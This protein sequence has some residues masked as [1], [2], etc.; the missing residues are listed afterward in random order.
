MLPD[1]VKREYLSHEGVST[2]RGDSIEK[3]ISNLAQKTEKCCIVSSALDRISRRTEH[4]QSIRAK[5]AGDHMVMS[6]L[7]NATTGTQ[8]NAMDAAMLSEGE[9]SDNQRASVQTW[10]ETRSLMMRDT[11]ERG[12]NIIQ[13]I[14]WAGAEMHPEVARVVDIHAQNAETFVD[15]V[16]QTSARQIRHYAP[17]PD[18]LLFRDE[19]GFSTTREDKFRKF[20]LEHWNIKSDQLDIIYGSY[21][22]S[23][24]CGCAS[25]Q[26]K[27]TAECACPCAYCKTANRQCKCQRGDCECNDACDCSCEVCHKVSNASLFVDV[28]TGLYQEAGGFC[29]DSIYICL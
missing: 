19:G 18:S 9:F 20:L 4:C 22:N 12:L 27:H 7:W 13:P 26:R 11:T 21:T 2:Y 24:E 29:H 28:Q 5:L 25:A 8:V 10:I 3:L 15:N 23:I 14:I 16:N 6:L 1:D 17:I